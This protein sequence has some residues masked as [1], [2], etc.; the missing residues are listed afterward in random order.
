M[1]GPRP[2][3]SILKVK[4]YIPGKDIQGGW[5]LASNE[6]PLGCSPHA[7]NA[8]IQAAQNVAVYP[9]GSAEQLRL[10]IAE[11]HRID[12]SR[13]ICGA[14]SDEIFQFIA[15]AYMEPG[16]EIVQ[17]E[18]GFLVYAIIAQQSGAT[19]IKARELN[20][21][22]DVDSILDCVTSKT[23]V[24]FL[25]NPNNPTGSYLPWDEIVRLHTAIPSSVLLVL[26]EAYYEYV[27]QPDYK[28]GLALSDTASNVLTTRTF[29]KAYGLAGLRLGWAFGSAEIIDTL[30]RARGAFNLTSTAL[31]AGIVAL[32]DDTFLSESVEFNNM[33]LRK[34]TEAL[35]SIGL[36]VY[37]SVCNFILVDFETDE[38]AKMA[39]DFLRRNLISVRSMG[40]YGLPNCLRISIGLEEA[41]ELVISRLKDFVQS[42]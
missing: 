1:S 14:G 4:P 38:R 16:D 7:T 22:A 8:I 2:L 27:E 40:P 24:I 26:D 21:V 25:A 42:S 34:L 17:T 41:N 15:R 37:P 31:A 10:A 20:L 30:N 13:I 36:T 29:S 12:A 19:T 9:D 18:H 6:N 3:S 28:S 39:D 32:N 33:H 23:K 35:T 11:K 5:K